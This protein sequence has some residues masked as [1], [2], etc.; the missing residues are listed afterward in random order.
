MGRD[1]VARPYGRFFYLPHYL[2]ERGHE[3]CS[4]LLDYK[5]AAS[6]D[7]RQHGIRWVCESLAYRGPGKYLGKLKQLIHETGPDWIIGFSDTYFGILAERFAR[8]SGIRCCID[9]YDNYES[10]IP[11]MKPLHL[12]WRRALSGAD[13][14]TAVGPDLA[15]YLSMQRPG[16]PAVVIPMAA[17]PVG[18]RPMDRIECRRRMNLPPGRKFVG[19]CGALHKNRGIEVLFQAF[20]LLHHRDPEV[21]LLLSG[22]SWKNVPLPGSACSLG[23]V[24]DD[25]MTTLLNCMDVL[26]VINRATVFGNYSYPVKLYE[27]MCCQIPVV[28]TETPATRWILRDYPEFLVPPAQPDVLCDRIEQNLKAGRVDYGHIPDWNSACGSFEKALLASM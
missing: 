14:V 8:K 2:A 5:P 20:D 26:T 24:Q 7:T 10:Y 22:R 23:Y 21:S 16:R 6:L 1:L 17:D 25:L 9:A 13:L 28:A 27:A 19:Y 15:D 11:W 3:V 4:L 12:L 18:F